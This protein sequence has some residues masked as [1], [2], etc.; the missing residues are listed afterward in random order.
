[1][2]STGRKTAAII[3]AGPAGLTAAY[4]LLSR[5]DIKPAVFEADPE[6]VGGISRTVNYKGNRIDIGG[7]RFFSKSD[8]VMQWWAQ[9]LPV[10]AAE[11]EQTITYQ[12]SMRALTEGLPRAGEEA[13]DA[14]M[15]VRP[16]KTRIIHGG[17][18]FSY[19]VELSLD[20]LRKLGIIKTLRIGVTYLWAVLFPIKPER[21]LEDF[22]LN[23]F[24]RELYETFFKSY[25]EKVWGMRCDQMSAEWGAQRVKGLSISKAILHAARKLSGMGALSG[26]GTE[27]SLIEQF[28]YPT[29]GP[30]FM[31][32][33]VAERVK[34]LGGDLHM[35][36]RVVGIKREGDSFV[37]T[38]RAADGSESHVA[39]DYVFSTTDV[40]NL[41]SI[42]EPKAPK[43]VL[44][45]SDAL[46]YR[47]FLTAGLLLSHAPREQGGEQLTDTWMY[48]HE[49][50]VRAGR[51][52]L[53]HNWH[54][55]LV[56]E[57]G[58]GWIGLEYFCNEGDDLWQMSDEQLVALAQE[59]LAAIGLLQDA[60]VL[61]GTVIK[62]PKAY[63][64]YFGAYAKFGDVREYLDTVPNLYP[65]GRNGMHR[66]NNQ[67]H[68]ML[69]A[70][71]AVDNIAH[72][73]KDKSN[74]WSINAEEE[75][76]EQK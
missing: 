70:M 59:E 54:P 49:P 33:V 30:G 34:A 21:T 35:G 47:D 43:E 27:T 65:I 75:Y 24:G 62:Q 42:L 67:D 73:K 7:H 20:T 16:R 5:T 8:R 63:P 71:T 12:R 74:L 26:K 17:R 46:E 60:E 31:W 40:R 51:V 64:G 38:V 44:A 10:R 29:F 36:A 72:G 57:E 11:G 9:F 19:P 1:M 6:Y 23:R 25:T 41:L 37:L 68:S 39:A 66:Y 48:I 15:H 13:G 18:F 52:Q 4:E 45:V 56:A 32:E 53:F 2:S 55:K 3:G 58:R 22:F 61:D 50:G 69:A 76:H 14:V 28:L